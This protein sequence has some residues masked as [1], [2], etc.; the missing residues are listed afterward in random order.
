MSVCDRYQVI[1]LELPT[2]SAWHAPSPPHNQ[3]H[4]LFTP[5]CIDPAA[6]LSTPA[7]PTYTA[8]HQ[9]ILFTACIP[10]CSIS[11]TSNLQTRHL[12]NLNRVS[13]TNRTLQIQGSLKSVGESDE[14]KRIEIFRR[15]YFTLFNIGQNVCYDILNI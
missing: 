7:P 12:L 15:P 1:E 5:A 2:W 8:D 11:Y 13:L 3:R 10:S 6:L 4:Q 9:L 14:M